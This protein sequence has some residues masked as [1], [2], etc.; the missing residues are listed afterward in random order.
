M[1]VPILAC[2]LLGL[3]VLPC[4]RRRPRH[5]ATVCTLLLCVL[6]T[7]CGSSAEDNTLTP[8]KMTAEDTSVLSVDPSDIFRQHYQVGKKLDQ[9]R[10]YVEVWQSGAVIDRIFFQLPQNADSAIALPSRE[11]VLDLTNQV[12]GFAAGQ[13]WKQV[14]F[15]AAVGE[16]VLTELTLDLPTQPPVSG[17][18]TSWL[19]SSAAERSWPIES[20]G[21]IIIMYLPFN[22]AGESKLSVY[23]CSYLMENPQTLEQYA[24]ALVVKAEFSASGADKEA[25]ETDT[26]PTVYT[27]VE[28]A[29]DA[30]VMARGFDSL[31]I[32]E[33]VYVTVAH[34]IL[35]TQEAADTTTVYAITT[36]LCFTLRGG[37]VLVGGGYKPAAITFTKDAAGRYTLRD[38]WQPKDGDGYEAEL[39]EKFPADLVQPALDIDSYL[40]PLSQRCYA[41]ALTYCGYDPSS[42]IKRM[43]DLISAKPE[44][45]DKLEDHIFLRRYDY[46][47]LLILKDYTLR[48]IFGEFLKEPQTGVR[49]QLMAKLMSDLLGGESIGE[50]YQ[51]GQ[52]YFERWKSHVLALRNQHTPDFFQES[53]PKAYMLLEML[54]KA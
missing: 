7:G 43:I 39:R 54:G 4:W 30:A 42:E 11:G 37:L 29:V 18:G 45:S 8:V 3:C 33:D 51:D 41:D 12:S 19:G 13:P 44:D 1:F 46:N 2:C 50:D 15:Q 35:G 47:Q 16:Q 21:S 17:V 52:A 53:A 24:Y 31:K 26:G 14:T 25:E 32:D 22:A 9:L 5:G 10:L 27:D 20:D 28:A 40:V 49:A 34:Q 48:Y 23:D 6:L 36:K 38:Y